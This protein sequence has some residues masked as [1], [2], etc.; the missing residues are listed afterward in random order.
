MANTL[1]GQRMLHYVGHCGKV[2][3][4]HYCRFT[5]FGQVVP[6]PTVDYDKR[7]LNCFES[8]T[9]VLS[10]KLQAPPDSDSSSSD[11]NSVVAELATGIA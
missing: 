5:V 3:S 9:L 2:Q 6:E 11:G 1:S 4:L 8:D 7:C 10:P